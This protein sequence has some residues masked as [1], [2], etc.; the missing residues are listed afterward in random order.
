MQCP[1]VRWGLFFA[2]LIIPGSLYGAS[3]IQTWVCYYG[4]VFGPR[5]YGRFDLAVLDS[6]HHPLLGR[7][8]PGHPPILLGYVSVG[9]V[10]EESPGW[11]QARQQ[12]YLIRKNPQWNSWIVDV[13]SS[14][15]QHV[16]FETAFPH[17][18]EEGFDGFFLDT[19]DSSLH[20]AEGKEKASFQGT[21]EALCYIVETL[22]SRYP[23]KPIAVNRGLPLLPSI[24]PYIDFVVVE[25]LYSYYAGADRGYVRV[26]E[27]TRGMLLDHVRKGLQ[28]NPELTVLTLDYAG[29]GER[30]LAMEAISFSRKNGF[31]PYVSTYKLD[32][33]FYYT[34]HP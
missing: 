4:K 16:L 23:G 27:K 19:I 15:W 12:P 10:H 26:D 18:I 7:N 22:R 8:R 9:E 2:L 24:A 31:V 6:R 20:L 1:L 3:R 28:V 13:R 14:G 17:V 33:I 29:E 11:S 5:I 32:Q 25:D 34:L 21:H 30:T